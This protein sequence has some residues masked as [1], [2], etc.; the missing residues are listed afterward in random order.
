MKT[1][2]ILANSSGGL[3]DFRNELVLELLKKYQVVVSVPDDVAVTQL[4][5]E[6]CQVC[7]TDIN[8]R[9]MNPVQDAGLFLAY[10]KLIKA[11]KPDLILTY[12]IKPNIYGGMCARIMKIPYI[13]NITGLG[14]T[15]ERG[16]MLQRMVVTMYRTALKKAVCV[17]FQNERNQNIFVENGIYGQKSRRVNGSG[18]NL[19]VHPY[20]PYPGHE[21]P[22][23]L[24]VG[25]LM[26]EKGIEEFLYNA[27]QYGNRAE[28]DII[29]YCEEA[30]EKQV[31]EL[32][33]EGLLKF[34]GFQKDVNAFYR[35]ADAVVI[36]SY[37]EGMSNVLLEGASTGRPV[38][39]TN[40]PG[41]KEAV[42]DNVTGYLF[43]PRS[44][45]ALGEVIEQFLAMPVD[46][47][48]EMGKAARKKMEQ[49]FNRMQVVEAYMEEIQSVLERNQ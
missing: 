26:K 14:T 27:K 10:R 22:K 35:D 13:T 28:F 21:K 4:E 39:A 1:V 23:F 46:A 41:C 40:I 7:H 44:E 25:R 38:L 16:G 20:E 29:G 9:G 30:Y 19:D 45:T 49:E 6:G 24:Y 15:F 32:S 5:E 43:T 37:H 8:R 33:K 42:E 47:R 36:A 11:V 18:V 2:L 31:E 12:T 3:Y 34:H 17:F 48:E